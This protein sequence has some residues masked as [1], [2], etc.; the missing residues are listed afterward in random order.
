MIVTNN[1]LRENIEELAKLYHSSN[2]NLLY[3]YVRRIFK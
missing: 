3:R 2:V 1:I